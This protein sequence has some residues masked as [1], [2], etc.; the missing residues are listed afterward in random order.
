MTNLDL[1]HAEAKQGTFAEGS[2]DGERHRTQSMLVI[3]AI[4]SV[5]IIVVAA[6]FMSLF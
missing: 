1:G 5:I 4:A 6:L 2:A 3:T